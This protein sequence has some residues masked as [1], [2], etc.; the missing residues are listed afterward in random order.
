M[1]ACLSVIAEDA[2]LP[3]HAMQAEDVAA[4]HIMAGLRP[5][6]LHRVTSH[7]KLTNE[8][9]S[10]FSVEKLKQAQEYPQI[11][12]VRDFL[13]KRYLV[14][15][16]YWSYWDR[17]DPLGGTPSNKLPGQTSPPMLWWEQRRVA[18]DTWE[19]LNSGVAGEAMQE[20]HG[21]PP[22]PQVPDG[23]CILHPGLPYRDPKA[24]EEHPT[25]WWEWLQK[26]PG[27][28]EGEGGMSMKGMK[29]G[30]MDG[31]KAAASDAFKDLLGTYDQKS[32]RKPVRIPEPASDYWAEDGQTGFDPNS[33]DAPP[34]EYVE[35][36]YT[37]STP[38]PVDFDQ[39]VWLRTNSFR[40][41]TLKGFPR[42]LSPDGLENVTPRLN[43]RFEE[44]EPA[45]L[46]PQLP[47]PARPRDLRFFPNREQAHQESIMQ[48]FDGN[49]E[50]GLATQMKRGA[51]EMLWDAALANI[52]GKKDAGKDLLDL[53]NGEPPRPKMVPDPPRWD[54]S[55]VPTDNFD[56][57]FNKRM[58][59]VWKTAGGM[60]RTHGSHARES[61]DNLE[62]YWK[63][64]S[65]P[66]KPL[67]QQVK[68]KVASLEQ[69]ST[70][71]VAQEIAVRS[72]ALEDAAAAD[73]DTAA[74]QVKL[75][76]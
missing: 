25:L 44:D 33:S 50:G 46:D 9:T 56:A 18:A 26:K 40:R 15:P 10:F 7:G 51:K 21:K 52:K 64:I 42:A 37:K 57:M 5:G 31:M 65:S 29:K 49:Y 16:S 30:L 8:V 74:S 34:P 73:T 13:S 58:D 6:S 41:P 62:D 53:K 54:A 27:Q 22:D 36:K 76:E 67:L 69:T 23:R 61:L 19:R 12:V 66:A 71:S 38:P 17:P 68:E 45:T 1:P 11:G 43:D 39:E 28:A 2:L 63:D 72:E 47:R 59:T 3:N 14:D 75:E 24:A 60:I 20:Y 4:E 48:A 70:P 35:P 32:C 55:Q